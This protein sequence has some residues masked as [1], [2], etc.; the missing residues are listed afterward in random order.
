MSLTDMEVFVPSRSRPDRS[1]T[2]EA[3]EG[4]WEHVRLVVP[5]KQMQ[6]Y[7]PL[8]RRHKVKLMGCPVDGIARTRQW[9]GQQ[10][11]DRFLMLD[12]DLRF[13]RRASYEDVTLHKFGRY[14]MQ[15]MLTFTSRLLTDFAHVAISARGGNNQLK[16]FPTVYNKRPLRAL[17]YRK[18]EFLACVHG[19]VQ[20]MEDFDI[21]LQLIGKGYENAVIV[22][23]A[24]DQIVTQMPGGCSDYRT[25]DMHNTNVIRM[26]KLHPGVVKVVE[27]E[28]RSA[29]AVK[30]GLAKRKELVIYWEKAHAKAMEDIL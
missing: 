15:N 18:R 25:L 12:D 30:A 8:A 24:Q 7:I 9:I 29:E 16:G 23:Y 27:K 20:I 26:A 28:N 17:A 19:R 4:K 11:R 2:L 10:A 5:A 13:Y 22:Q 1:L 3:V 21:T 14:D 6:A